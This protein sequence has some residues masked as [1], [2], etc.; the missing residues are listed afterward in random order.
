MINDIK[1]LILNISTK[2]HHVHFMVMIYHILISILYNFY[3]RIKGVE[4]I[5]KSSPKVNITLT[6]ILH[7]DSTSTE[8]YRHISHMNTDSKPPKQYH[9][10]KPNTS[11]ELKKKQKLKI[12]H[13]KFGFLIRQE[14]CSTLQ[15]LVMNHFWLGLHTDPST[16]TNKSSK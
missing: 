14:S 13:N 1:S 3:E 5:P 2:K 8:N 9:H 16:K 12:G 6:Q 11:N 10:G 7:K 4:T 15:N